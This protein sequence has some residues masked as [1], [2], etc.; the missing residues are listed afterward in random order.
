MYRQFFDEVRPLNELMNQY[1]VNR[2]AKAQEAQ[3]KATVAKQRSQRRM[4]Q[5]DTER[6]D[7]GSWV[8]G[9]EEDNDDK[10][11]DRYSYGSVDEDVEEWDG[12]RPD[13]QR[14]QQPAPRFKKRLHKTK[15]GASKRRGGGAVDP[16]TAAAI[17]YAGLTEPV[18]SKAHRRKARQVHRYEAQQAQ[19]RRHRSQ[20]E[21]AFRYIF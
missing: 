3:E 2:E 14:Q 19:A 8:E 1:M 18:L 15:V 13:R 17:S 21:E 20:T 12:G 5:R 16:L 9:E 11:E 7:D 4:K 6:E 10:G